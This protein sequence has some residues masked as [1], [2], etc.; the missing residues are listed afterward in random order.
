MSALD[1]VRVNRGS[2]LISVAPFSMASVTYLKEMGWFSAALL[3][4]MRM[5]S[6]FLMSIQ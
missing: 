4:M 2:T 5:Q 3:P 6:L 1:E